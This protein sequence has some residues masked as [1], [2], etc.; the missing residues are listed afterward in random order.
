MLARRQKSQ[1]RR[2]YVATV[3]D[4][5]GQFLVGYVDLET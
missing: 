3:R 1:M 2:H 5:L 4:F